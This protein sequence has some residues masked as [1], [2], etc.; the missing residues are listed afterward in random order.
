MATKKKSTVTLS[1]PKNL[2][3][4]QPHST[5]HG[6]LTREEKEA[7]LKQEI[8]PAALGVDYCTKLA[9]TLV[10]Q[11]VSVQKAWPVGDDKHKL[12]VAL[13]TAI[14]LK[15]RNAI[16]AMLITQMTGVHAAVISALS[17]AGIQE[18]PYEIA[19]LYTNRASRLMR[20]YVQQVEALSKLRGES[21][22]SRV[23][24]EHVNVNAGGQAIVGAITKGRS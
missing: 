20:L 15:P 4:E 2:K 13:E 12:M 17:K 19:E 6:Q 24:V 21:G 14:T 11:I 10:N 18:Q 16:Q 9:G 7:F 3:A 22:Q 1:K 8:I 5:P 23:V